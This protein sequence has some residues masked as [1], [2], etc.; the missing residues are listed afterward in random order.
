M[1]ENMGFLKRIKTAIFKLENYG[2]FLGER[3]SKAFKFFFLLILLSSLIVSLVASYDFYKMID[4][5][6]SYIENEMPD[7]TY[8][9]ERLS[10]S[11]NVEAY[12]KTYEFRLFINTDEN[13]DEETIRAYKTKIYDDNGGMILLKDKAIYVYG[14]QESEETYSKLFEIY[15]DRKSVV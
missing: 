3:C 15:G 14:G 6:Y 4:K 7:F 1:E 12:D 5:A 10:A 11:L 2:V 13:V 9:N 8:E